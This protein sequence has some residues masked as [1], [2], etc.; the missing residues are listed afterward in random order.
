MYCG[1]PL[2]GDEPDSAE[3]SHGLCPVCY[4]R[5]IAGAGTDAQEF[6]DALPF[7]VF[8]V[9]DDVRI[10]GA[11]QSARS[12]VSVEI[13]PDTSPL[14]GDVFECVHASEPG[15]CGKTVHCRSCA[16]RRAVTVTGETGVAQRRVPAYMDL[17]GVVGSNDVC[18]TVTTQKVGDLVML[19]VESVDSAGPA[20]YD[21]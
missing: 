3:I 21:A 9:T 5:F 19:T 14:G 4:P 6:L 15:G 1:V 10:V 12:M 13:D 18:F 11:N 16:I 7:P 2:E 20:T 8:V 17:G